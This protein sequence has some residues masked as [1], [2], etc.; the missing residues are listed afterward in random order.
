MQISISGQQL[1]VTEPLRNYVNEKA[2]RL[3]RHFDFLQDAHFVLRAK[4]NRHTAEA[5][6]NGRH[7]R[8]HATSSAETLYAAIDDLMDKLHQQ[9]QRAKEKLTSH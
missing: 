2:A 1:E 6:I 4:K 8:L 7:T 3:T 5:T 9:G